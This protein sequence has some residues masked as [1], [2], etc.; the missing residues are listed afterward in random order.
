MV[1]LCLQAFRSILLYM[2]LLFTKEKFNFVNDPFKEQRV[3]CCLECNNGLTSTDY[4]LLCFLIVPGG[5]T[6]VPSCAPEG[7]V[8]SLWD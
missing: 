3:F 5:N 8:F 1:Y 4:C 6:L 7:S 2:K